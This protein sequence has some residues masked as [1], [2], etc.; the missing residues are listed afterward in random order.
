MYR[1]ENWPEIAFNLAFD[2]P[3]LAESKELAACREGID[4]GADA[5]LKALRGVRVEDNR[6]EH[7]DGDWVYIHMNA[8]DIEGFTIL[9]IPD[10][11]HGS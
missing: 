10:E 9:F 11:E 7:I 4:I 8:K 2:T 3:Y 5:M 6:I 1:P